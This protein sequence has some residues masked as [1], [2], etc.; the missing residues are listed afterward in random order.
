MLFKLN[1]YVL[2]NPEEIIQVSREDSKFLIIDWKNGKQ[3]VIPDPLKQLFNKIVKIPN[4][5]FT[6]EL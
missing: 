3:S 6:E 4:Y 1:S 2:I 5:V